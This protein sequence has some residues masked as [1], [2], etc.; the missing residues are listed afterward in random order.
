MG[1]QENKGKKIVKTALTAGFIAL[2]LI[3][4]ATKPQPDVR[5]LHYNEEKRN[6]MSPPETV[7]PKLSITP[8]IGSQQDD[9]KVVRDFGVVL[10]TWIAPYKD[11]NGNL[12]A[13]HELYV[14]VKEADWIGAE[15]LPKRATGL[16][17]PT[18]QIPFVVRPESVD[19]SSDFA[20]E[21]IRQ[22]LH[23]RSDTAQRNALPPP[24]IDSLDK[25]DE[26]ILQYINKSRNSTTD[27][28]NTKENR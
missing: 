12:V 15:T 14:V 28:N 9:A 11:T 10:K 5:M 1:Y 18:G 19:A 22:Y 24:K 21:E 23:Q 20:N 4:C 13:S 3:G 25:N 6:A 16:R 26:A 2:C 7:A 27:Q 8:I 17:S